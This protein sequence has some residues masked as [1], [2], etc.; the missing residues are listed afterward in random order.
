M[1]GVVRNAD[2]ILLYGLRLLCWCCCV[3]VSAS[4]GALDAGG[5]QTFPSRS[6]PS[7]GSSA[8]APAK[9]EPTTSPVPPVKI[10]AFS[11]SYTDGLAKAV[12]QDAAQSSE[13]YVP[14]GVICIQFLPFAIFMS[15]QS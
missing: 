7:L 11:G 1:R 12:A 2:V 9:N 4:G 10:T 6:S 14:L 15:H 5:H 3:E 13:F 8:A